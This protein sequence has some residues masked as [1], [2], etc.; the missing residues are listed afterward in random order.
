MKGE[1]KIGTMADWTLEERAAKEKEWRQALF[2]L[3]LQKAT[4]QLD[5]PMKIK[6]LRRDIARL[7]TLASQGGAI[8]SASA[9]TAASAPSGGEAA[10]A[11]SVA[12]AKTPAGEPAK[13]T[14][15]AAK[16]AAKA[17]ARKPTSKAKPMAQAKAK[18]KAKA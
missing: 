10:A 14:A 13:K 3:R 16:K 12:K 17:P 2:T 6:S 5:N 18:A 8:P 11:K 9:E 4:G 15:P 1:T 7:K